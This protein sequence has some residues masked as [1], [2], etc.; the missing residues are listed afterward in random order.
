MIGDHIVGVSAV[1]VGTSDVSGRAFP[2][3]R[4]V[5]VRTWRVVAE[6]V[7]PFAL[8]DSIA[9]VRLAAKRDFITGLLE[10]IGEERNRG[11]QRI[12]GVVAERSGRVRVHPR[13]NDRAGRGRC[14]E[15]IRHE[16]IAEVHALAADPVVVWR[17]EKA[18]AGQAEGVSAL[19]FSQHEDNVW[20]ARAPGALRPAPVRQ[21]GGSC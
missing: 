14:T 8:P 15:R 12:P 18:I 21:Q 16:R 17:L 2:E 7:I 19:P 1:G 10:E 20:P 3:H 9:D 11:G 5:I 13:Q 4:M 6:I